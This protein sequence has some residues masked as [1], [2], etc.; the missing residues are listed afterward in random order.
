MGPLQIQEFKNI[1]QQAL[2]LFIKRSVDRNCSVT[3]EGSLRDGLQYRLNL[4]VLPEGL[5]ESHVN[6]GNPKTPDPRL[7]DEA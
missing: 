2:Q 6:A 7:E 3:I 5:G 1:V 4:S